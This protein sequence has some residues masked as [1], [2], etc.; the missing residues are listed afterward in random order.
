VPYLVVDSSTITE[1][2]PYGLGISTQNIFQSQYK[3]LDQTISNLKMLLLTKKGELIGDINFGTDLVFVLFQPNAN[4]DELKEQ[5]DLYIRGPVQVYLPDITIETID[6]KTAEE[7]PTL[8][9][10]IVVT[11]TI[12]LDL[13]N[14]S[15]QVIISANQTGTIIVQQNNLVG[16]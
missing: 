16:Q 8:T 14:V 13:I 4:S 5:I 6:V 9:N 11:L 15:A 1:T 12:S 2:S 10:D 7:D 3:T